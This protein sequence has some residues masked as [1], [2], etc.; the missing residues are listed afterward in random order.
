[1]SYQ[2]VLVDD[3]GDPVADGAY[4][5]TFSIYDVATG[6]SPLWQ[7]TQTLAVVDGVFDAVLGHD[8]PLALAFDSPCWLG[9]T[10]TGDDEMS[11]RLE[12]TAVPYARRAAV[13][14][15][16]EDDDWTI[17]GTDL[18]RL[19]GLIGVGQAAP[20]NKLH[21]ADTSSGTFTHALK[22]ENAGG[23]VGT[24]TG[25]VFKVDSSLENRAKGGIAY[26][27]TATWN[28]GDLHILQNSGANPNRVS[29][30]DA[31]MT[32]KSNG[33]VGVGTKTPGVKFEIAGQARIAGYAWPT[34][35]TGMEIA[36]N[37]SLHRGY[38][39]VF[40]RDTDEWGQ[41]FLG[42][43][44]VGIGVLN[45][46]EKLQVDGVI[47]STSGGVKFPDGTVQTTA[48]GGAGGGLTLPY[49][50]S[51]ATT[52]PAFAAR[53]LSSGV[54]ILGEGTAVGVAGECDLGNLGYVGSTFAGVYGFG[55][56]GVMGSSDAGIGVVAEVE[57][58]VALE[59]THSN[60]NLVHLATA[61]YAAR[62]VHHLGNAAELG[63]VDYGVR[64]EGD[65]RIEGD[66]AV[67][68]A[69]SAGGDVEAGGDLIV[70]GA[71]R[72]N[73]GPNG[74]AP[75]PRPAYDS[76]WVA[77]SPGQE[78]ELTHN[79]GGNADDY[80]VDFQL[81]DSGGLSARGRHIWGHGGVQFD[82]GGFQGAV[83]QRLNDT[84]IDVMRADD[85]NFAD[86]VRVRIWVYN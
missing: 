86:L 27:R 60:N 76:G 21:I 47:Y 48:G 71:Y 36:Y 37:E 70:D 57:S 83:W 59:A 50:G 29:L 53:N 1:M 17:S 54:G 31:A 34:A 73:I 42:G 7:E 30:D 20:R 8:T 52:G 72:G 69:V 12:L 4:E 18:Y 56:K 74:G 46:S 79:L 44:N 24:A 49:A 28:R 77:I 61:S 3:Q 40:D 55:Q 35:G 85:D 62:A 33:N 32:I 75:F 80:V 19:D 58:G 16:G 10:I 45:P 41:L 25:L 23:A 5:L 78:L 15:V 63:G 6:G 68:G 9:V 84:S 39:Q 11:P 51:A 64:S 26:E 43:G 67:D 13:A 14:D 38:V 81:K 22:L 2:G 65:A 82:I 66:I